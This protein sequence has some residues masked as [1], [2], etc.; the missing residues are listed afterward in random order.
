MIV[1]R[2]PVRIRDNR[3]AKIITK[4]WIMAGHPVRIRDNRLAKIITKK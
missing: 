1:G 2:H 3:L 4:K